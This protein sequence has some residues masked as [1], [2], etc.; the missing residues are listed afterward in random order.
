[1]INFTMQDFLGSLLA[2]LLFPFV[3]LIP[4]YVI[5]WAL[6]LFDFRSRT[7][8][9]RYLIGIVLSNAVMPI[10]TFLIYRFT[11][12]SA[13]LASLFLFTILF[14]V[15]GVLPLIQQGSLFPSSRLKH[16][17]TYQ[18]LALAMAG[19]WVVLSMGLLLD[20]QFGNKLYF[21]TVAYDTTTRIAII[22]AITRTGIPPIN[23]GYFP[24]HPEQLNFLYY[25]WYI[26][27]SLI[28]QLGGNLVNSRQAMLAGVIWTGLALMATIALYLRLRNRRARY[29]WKGP[30]IGIQ[31]LLVSGVDFVPVLVLA[32][33]AR[34]IIGQMMFN[35]Q[36][37]SWNIPIESWLNA[38][39]W[40]PNHLAAV[41]Q[42]VTAML[43]I[44]SVHEGTGRQRIAAGAL[45]TAAFASALG[46]SVWVTLVF[47]IAW[48]VW[49]LI[50]ARSKSSRPLFWVMG[51]SGLSGA[52]L[53][54]P[55]I[56]GLLKSGG[57]AAG[58]LPIAFYIRPFILSTLLVPERLQ[59]ISNLVLLPLNYFLELGFFFVVGIY[60]IQHRKAYEKRNSHF[61]Q[62][63]LVLLATV[64][65]TLSFVQS[66]IIETNILAIRPW[67]LG[68][69]VL[70]IWATDVMQGWLENAPPCISSF[71]RVSGNKPRIGRTVQI[72]LLL[73]LLTTGLEAFSTRMWPFL[74]DWN[75]AGFP[76]DLSPDR[77]LGRRT[78]GASLAY[79]FV[80]KLPGT[81]V[82]QYNPDI[83]LDRP[84]GLYGTVQFAISDRIA[85]GVPQAYFQRAKTGI[86]DIFDREETWSS[87]DR[88]CSNFF[89]NTLI[90]NDLDPLWKL[91]PVLER[92]RKPLYQNDYYS[93]L[94][95]GFNASP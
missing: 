33:A 6:N 58:G 28:D 42:C 12:G 37:E 23:P 24:G 2:L 75:V 66:T 78:Y 48:V 49:A 72:L 20:L 44:L 3:M 38:A 80:D 68:Q 93:I 74:V 91:L 79:E 43:G 17:S 73:G 1:M 4:G 46:T 84:S 56:S 87:I 71:F 62:A 30:L 18:R 15:V 51:F 53:S 85:Y 11:S 57:T 89:I 25:Y 32:L 95:C 59:T 90:I 19:T 88:S 14:A 60:W 21:P 76:N 70:L 47:A 40:V 26:A 54:I 10:F 45:A 94:H 67:L 16:L 63:E 41:T 82:A 5:G 77:N 65:V 50:L 39:T 86:A 22:N 34:K 69:F 27:E 36:I 81:V 9:I 52:V 13:V 61:L 64:A 35:G 8:L 83:V 92:E 7:Q 55:F 29:A 31:L